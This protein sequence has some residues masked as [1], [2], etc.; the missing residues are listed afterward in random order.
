MVKREDPPRAAVSPPSSSTLTLLL[1]ERPR[2]PGGGL[3]SSPMGD[4][5]GPGPAQSPDPNLPWPLHLQRPGSREAPSPEP[6]SIFWE[7]GRTALPR[8]RRWGAA[9]L[10][11]LGCILSGANRSVEFSGFPKVSAATDENTFRHLGVSVAPQ[12]GGCG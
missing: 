2:G 5:G 7:F 4:T 12:E 11:T 6:P 9:R 10:H 8:E 1:T 3:Q